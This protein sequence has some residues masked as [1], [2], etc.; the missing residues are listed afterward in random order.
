MKWTDDK[1]ENLTRFVELGFKPQEIAKML[2]TTYKSITSKMFLLGL[3]VVYTEKKTCKNCDI[4]F[5]T[6]ITN[7]KI[8]CSSS[9]SAIYNNKKRT[10]S[11]ETKSKIS[12]TLKNK[13]KKD[14]LIKNKI[15]KVCKVCKVR[16]INEKHKRICNNCKLDYYEYYRPSCVFNFNPYDFPEEFNLNLVKNNGWYSPSNKKNNLYGVSKDHKLS[17]MDGYRNKINT[18]IISHPANCELIL[19]SDN[20]VKKDKSS[21]TLNE[22]LKKIE[23][24][25]VK[26][27]KS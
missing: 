8:F 15:C 2:K 13:P 4:Q 12:N 26:Y 18:N 1:I 27:G 9:C 6:H 22:L 19:F 25:N 14:K 16:E 3:K 23:E 10:L 24:W 21:I 5:D 17:I 7:G 11:D 20:S